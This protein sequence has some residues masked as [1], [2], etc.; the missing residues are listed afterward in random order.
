MAHKVKV[1][2]KKEK[3]LRKRLLSKTLTD[4]D[5]ELLVEIVKESIELGIIPSKTDD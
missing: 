2:R 5:Y 3:A 1:S 4:D